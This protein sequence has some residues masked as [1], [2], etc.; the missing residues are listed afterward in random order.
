MIKKIVII[1]IFLSF[2]MPVSSQS[3]DTWS[4]MNLPDEPFTNPEFTMQAAVAVDGNLI[5]LGAKGPEMGVLGFLYGPST[6]P[7]TLELLSPNG[8][9]RLSTGSSHEI[10][11]R[12]E[13]EI[14]Y[15]DIEYSIN[16]GVTWMEIITNT[17]ND[18]CYEWNVPCDLSPS[19]LVRIKQAGGEVFDVSDEVFSIEDNMPPT[20]TLSV[21]PNILWPPNHKMIPVSAVVIGS[22]NCTLS[23][24]VQL[25][26]ITINEGDLTNTYDAIYDSS[27]GDGNTVDDIQDAEYGTEDYNFLLRAERAGTGTGRVY[28]IK[29]SITDASG[30]TASACAEVTVPHNQ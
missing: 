6:T 5:V 2:L 27:I 18:D 8:G 1:V 4:T 23:P 21:N 19:C 12:S 29:Y 10:T 15:V 24:L 22:D 13:G 25:D 30:N 16:N 14:Y 20:I 26:S 7:V 17:E 28:R 9:E 3:S 11:W